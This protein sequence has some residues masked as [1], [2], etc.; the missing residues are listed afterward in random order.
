MVICRYK[1]NWVLTKHSK[2]GLEFPGGKVEQKETPI[3]AAMRELFEETGGEAQKL[4][5]IGEYKVD[6]PAGAFVKAVFRA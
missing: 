1:G 5:P 6:D 2:R 3:Q 4:I